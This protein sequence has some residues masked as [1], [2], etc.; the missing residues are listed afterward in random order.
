MDRD[1]NP[2]ME[3]EEFSHLCSYVGWINP[4]YGKIYVDITGKF[5]LCSIDVMN[6]DFYMNGLPMLFYLLLSPMQNM[7]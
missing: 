3:Q 4:K 6:T 2:Q 5:P 1:I 7:K